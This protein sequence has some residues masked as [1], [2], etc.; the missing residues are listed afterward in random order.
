KLEQCV[1]PGS[2]YPEGRAT[3]PIPYTSSKKYKLT[4]PAQW[5]D[6]S[7][8]PYVTPGFWSITVY[9]HKDGTLPDT[10]NNAYPTIYQPFKPLRPDSNGDVQVLIQSKPLSV[11]S[12][13]NWLPGPE[14][15]GVDFY[16]ILRVYGPNG[17]MYGKDQPDGEP[18]PPWTAPIVTEYLEGEE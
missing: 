12:P 1:Y 17:K 7:T 10:Y 3:V 2:D 18:V 11:D 16:L 4:I 6:P 13:Y 9:K 8:L 15:S 14:D 5:L